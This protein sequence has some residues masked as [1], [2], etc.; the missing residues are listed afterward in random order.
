MPISDISAT[1]EQIP[2][3]IEAVYAAAAIRNRLYKASLTTCA[4]ADSQ[5]AGPRA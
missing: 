4:G 2:T 1:T 5:A 3:S